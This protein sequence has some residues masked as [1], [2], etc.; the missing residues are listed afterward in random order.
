MKGIKMKRNRCDFRDDDNLYMLSVW[1]NE[2]VRHI[3]S[4]FLTLDDLND[5]FKYF[6]STYP[7]F[8]NLQIFTEN[9]LDICSYYEGKNSDEKVK[10]TL[11]QYL[12]GDTYEYFAQDM[13]KNPENLVEYQKNLF[14]R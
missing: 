4:P 11:R 9:T 7:R 1:D 3:R 2:E 12:F 10:L 6:H 14:N 5:W 8:I 13:K